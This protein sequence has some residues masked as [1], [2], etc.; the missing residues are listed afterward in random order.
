MGYKAHRI[1]DE[2]IAELIKKMGEEKPFGFPIAAYINEILWKYTTGKLISKESAWDNY[3]SDGKKENINPVLEK[4][5]SPQN[6]HVIRQKVNESEISNKQS[7][8]LKQKIG[9]KKDDE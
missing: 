1:S 7:S 8:A 6:V 5:H 9:N 4:I 3:F 2:V